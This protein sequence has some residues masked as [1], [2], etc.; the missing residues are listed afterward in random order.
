MATQYQEVL[1][2]VK[3]LGDKSATPK[4][5]YTK[6]LETNPKGWGTQT[7]IASVSGY[8]SRNKETFK[9]NGGVWLP[10]RTILKPLSIKTLSIKKQ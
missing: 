3:A 4:E 2:A 7:P 6:I 9:N 5:I 8:L 10:F 1:L